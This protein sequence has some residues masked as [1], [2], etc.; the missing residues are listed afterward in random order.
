MLENVSIGSTYRSSNWDLWVGGWE[1][2]EIGYTFRNVVFSFERL[3]ISEGGVIGAI[4]KD[5]NMQ[6]GISNDLLLIVVC[7]DCK[8][9]RL[10]M[11]KDYCDEL[12]DIHVRPGSEYKV[13]SSK[14]NCKYTSSLCGAT[15]VAYLLQPVRH[16]KLSPWNF[17]LG[18]VRCSNWLSKPI[19]RAVGS[20]LWY[21]VQ[22][23]DDSGTRTPHATV[24]QGRSPHHS[25]T[26]NYAVL[27]IAA[28]E[29]Y[30]Q[31]KN[32]ERMFLS[33]SLP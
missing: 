28:S 20:P 27:T 1:K 7:S 13:T 5:F 2:G 21:A 11:E 30:L 22:G 16:S 17:L 29:H 6:A 25:K 12:K 32:Q 23:L 33:V 18:K 4:R 26:A 8:R 9:L 14:P 3:G 31:D 19:G 24:R 15:T 10:E